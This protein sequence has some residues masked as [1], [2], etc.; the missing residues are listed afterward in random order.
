MM[1]ILNVGLYDDGERKEKITMTMA[2]VAMRITIINDDGDE[3]DDDGVDE[4]DGF[5]SSWSVAALRA[6]QTGSTQPSLQGEPSV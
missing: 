4:N 6:T 2:K 1:L 3:N 5:A